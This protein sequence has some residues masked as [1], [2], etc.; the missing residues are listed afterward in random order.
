[1][2]QPRQIA[3]L[4]PQFPGQ[5]HIF[6]WRE[7]QHLERMGVQVHLFST[8]PPPP[9]LISHSWSQ[10]AMDRTTYLASRSVPA[11]L[12]SLPKLPIPEILQEVRHDGFAVARDVA[13]STPAARRLVAECKRRG[14][15][16]VHAHSC[17]RAA[18][19]AALA[20][21]IG[22][23]DYSVTLHGPLQDYGPGQH[24]KWRRARFATIITHKIHAEV[25]AQLGPDLPA[26]IQ[27]Q[28]MG[29][30]A[31]T[32][33][34]DTPYQPPAPGHPL[35]IFTCARLHFV[36]GHQDLL[37]AMRLLLDR[38][39]NARLHI[40][41]EDDDGG[42]G[43]RHVLEQKVADLNLSDHVTLLGAIDADQVKR[44]LC[45]AHLFVL[46]SWAEPL[47]VAYMEAMSCATPTIGTDAGGVPELISNGRDG[48]LVPPK[49]PE[50]LAQAIAALAAD[51][52][53]LTRL[54][55]AGRQTVVDR[56]DSRLGAETLVREIWGD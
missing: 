39:L 37:D 10:Q 56:F 26:R 22:G 42:T 20:N 7:I 25:Q 16:H 30:D 50:A 34:R 54:S 40:A 19:I 35:R 55:A 6:F 15:T 31:D 17:G 41:G 13:I 53:T 8:T 9:G 21:R 23:L 12:A 11:L 49:N 47:G 28:P 14:I 33:R 4:V 1:M 32:L 24:L 3:Y 46:A 43:F 27:I 44:R 38:G 2:S 5:T 29:I 18:M 52:D 45:D 36:K 48:I 51:P